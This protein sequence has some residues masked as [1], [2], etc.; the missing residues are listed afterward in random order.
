MTNDD[1]AKK[2]DDLSRE[3]KEY[4]RETK[5]E[6]AEIK[7]NCIATLER[8]MEGGFK[9]T[10]KALL[11]YSEAIGGIH[12]DIIDIRGLLRKINDRLDKRE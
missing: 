7:T 4:R 9:A 3:L 12:E 5:E 10:T 1:I 6:I 8:R 2:L 11:K